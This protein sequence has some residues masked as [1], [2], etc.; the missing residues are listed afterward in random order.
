MNFSSGS[1]HSLRSD[2]K[3]QNEKQTERYC[4][5]FQNCRRNLQIRLRLRVKWTWLTR[6][7]TPMYCRM[8]TRQTTHMRYFWQ[9][10]NTGHTADRIWTRLLN[11]VS[12]FTIQ[13][14][15]KFVLRS[16]QETFHS[17]IQKMLVKKIRSELS[18]VFKFYRHWIPHSLNSIF[19][20]RTY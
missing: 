13:I 10:L 4:G 15:L 7:W 16:Y 3:L 5:Y 2:H 1:D 18:L 19:L 20:K 14:S 12:T 9:D 11:S 17:I 6:I 8:Q